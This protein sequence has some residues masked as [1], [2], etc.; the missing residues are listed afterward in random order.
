MQLKSWRDHFILSLALSAALSGLLYAGYR[1]MGYPLPAYDLMNMLIRV[2]DGG[3]ITFGIDTMTDIILGLSPNADLDDTAKTVENGMAVLQFL[4]LTTLLAWLYSQGAAW[5]NRRKIFLST[6]FVTGLLLGAGTGLAFSAISNRYYLGDTSPAMASLWIMGMFIVWGLVLNLVQLRWWEQENLVA[7]VTSPPTTTDSPLPPRASVQT[8]D[9][10]RFL[11]QVGGTSALIAVAGA[12]LGELLGQE[13]EIIVG[14][15]VVGADQDPDFIPA[16]GTRPEYTPLENH[17]RIDINT[18]P[19]PEVD[20]LTYLLPITGLVGQEL[21]LSLAD[22]RAY[23]PKQQYVTLSCISNRIAGR[24]ISTTRWTGVPLRTLLE[25]AQLPAEATH[26]KI[27]SLDGFYELVAL[28]LIQAD[29]RVML[30]Y[31]W[32]GV[33]LPRKHGF[34]LR[35]YIPDRYGM[36]QPKWIEKIEVVG[37][38]EEGYWVK[39]GWSKEAL[40]RTTSVID[41]VAL[42]EIYEDRGQSYIPIGGIAYSGDKQISKVEVRVNDGDWVEAQLRKPLSETTW[43]LWR[44]D[45]PLQ[46]GE[47]RFQVRATD[48][49]GDLQISESNPV[50]PD[51]ATGIHEVEEE[52]G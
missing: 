42:N 49:D 14:G 21:R 52:V 47:H 17:Y 10:R 24:L 36:K 26:L 19:L 3:I 13:P 20:E 45:W 25:P 11:I 23:P 16:T 50:R 38:W 18:G 34:P 8:L 6:Q 43:V 41:T 29:E 30:A 15:N 44:Y 46:A 40:V 39:R 9:R 32:D 7:L 4:G 5:L 1:L 31:E 28:D 48:G 27:S 2:L 51:G 37:Q 22:I 35:I 33:P 12:A